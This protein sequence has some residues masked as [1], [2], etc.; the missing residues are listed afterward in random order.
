MAFYIK[1][2]D[3]SPAFMRQFLNS[4]GAAVSL[5]GATVVFNMASVAGTLVCNARPAVVFTGTL[6][7]ELG[8]G[9]VTAA[10]GWMKYAW[11][12]PDTATP[13][14]Y[15]SEFQVTFGD[16]SVETAPNATW[17]MVTITPDISAAN[18]PG[19]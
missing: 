3:T 14:V 6:P 16:G 12:A 4:E 17:E 1:Q 18:Y 2:N 10:D 19:S 15:R 7:A 5:A 13:G 9:T 11:T 8:G